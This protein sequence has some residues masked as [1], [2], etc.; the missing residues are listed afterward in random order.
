MERD[1]MS[2]TLKDKLYRAGYRRAVVVGEY[3]Y[4]IN[5]YP[6][7]H[8]QRCPAE[9]KDR[10]WIDY[11]GNRIT[12]WEDIDEL[13]DEDAKPQKTSPEQDK[14]MQRLTDRLDRAKMIL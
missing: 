1:K 13:P 14:G 7:P 8:F 3:A 12:R 4:R 9:D 6:E 2:S 11:D 5:D 10:E